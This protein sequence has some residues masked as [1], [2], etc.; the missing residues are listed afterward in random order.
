MGIEDALQW[1]G[2]NLQEGCS[3]PE[4]LPGKF[5]AVD[6][7]IV[8]FKSILSLDDHYCLVQAIH[9]PIGQQFVL[10]A[11]I[12]HEIVGRVNSFFR[13]L[14]SSGA[15]KPI[16][17]VFDGRPYGSKSSEQISRRDNY[18]QNWLSAK[19]LL[20]NGASTSDRKVKDLLKTS[21][22]PVFEIVFAVQQH[23]QNGVNDLD[24]DVMVAPF[25]ADAQLAYPDGK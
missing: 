20:D 14:H 25:E 16:I 5:V 19:H 8:I 7:S 9:A 3:I 17:A 21:C 1:S 18:F 15:A 10:K 23:L 12:Q 13:R 22:F 6:T 11:D 24:I 4:V 2:V